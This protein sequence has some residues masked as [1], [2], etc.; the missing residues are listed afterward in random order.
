MEESQEKIEDQ[1]IDDA[2]HK[3]ATIQAVSPYVSE[4]RQKI[5]L[6]MGWIPNEYADQAAEDSAYSIL[7]NDSEIARCLHLHSCMSAGENIRVK[8]EDEKLKTIVEKFLKRIS[9]FMHARKSL[10]ENGMLFGLGIQRKFYK[11]FVMREF[12]RFEWVG[13]N[14]IKEVDTRR[15]RIERCTEFRDFL[16]WTMYN[17]VIDKYVKVLDRN[18]FP[19][20]MDGDAIQDYI[21]Y[22]HEEEELNPYFRGIGAV[23]YPIAYAK[24]MVLQYWRELCEGWAKPWL[25]ALMDLLKGSISASMGGDFKTATQRINDWLD[26]L[27]KARARHAIV[28]DKNDKLDVIEHGSTGNNIC[29]QFLQYADEKIALALLGAELTTGTGAGVGSYALGNV[30]RQQTET[31]IMYSRSR[32][33]EILLRDVVFDLLYRNRWN[34]YS[35]GISVPEPGDIEI[36]LYIKAEKQKEAA[37]NQQLTNYTGDIQKIL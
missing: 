33:E 11:K 24:S 4:L 10:I 6:Y 36:E 12:P 13:I 1:Q 29:M 14:S 32:L 34:L 25:V 7:K 16:Y 20:Q 15:V 37:M 22:F 23:L 18:D 28:M 21:W 26:V 8:C 19:G 2:K 9:G 5:G 27:E 3:L 17:P 31:L 30:H 35:L